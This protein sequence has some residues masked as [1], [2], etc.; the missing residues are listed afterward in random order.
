MGRR[1][2]AHQNFKVGAPCAGSKEKETIWQLSVQSA[3]LTTRTQQNTEQKS[4]EAKGIAQ[5]VKLVRDHR[6]GMFC[7]LAIVAGWALV[8]KIATAMH[9][10]TVV[11][12]LEQLREF[13]FCCL[14]LFVVMVI[15]KKVNGIKIVW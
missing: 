15:Y 5:L 6:D 2:V 1:R 13:T 11:H 8:M 9:L 4:V 12:R 14:F 7:V 3:G 10:M